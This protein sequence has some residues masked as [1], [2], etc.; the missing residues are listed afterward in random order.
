MKKEYVIFKRVCNMDNYYLSTSKPPFHFEQYHKQYGALF[1]LKQAI[2]IVGRL[3]K[4]ARET[5]SYSLAYG[6][7]KINE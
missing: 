1:T 4:E 6:Y 7:H 5:Y 3:N 2:K